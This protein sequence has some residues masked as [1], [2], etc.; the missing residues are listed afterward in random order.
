VPPAGSAFVDTVG[1][2]LLPDLLS[3]EVRAQGQR[4]RPPP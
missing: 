4:L 3:D 2:S 1:T